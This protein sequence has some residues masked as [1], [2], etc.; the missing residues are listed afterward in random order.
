MFEKILLPLPSEYF[1]EHAV[2]RAI[3]LASKFKSKLFLEY[4][5][6]EQMMVKVDSVSSGAVPCQSLDQMV[7]EVKNVEVGSESSVVFD[8]V[9]SLAKKK[10]IDFQKII[11]SGNHSEEI[12]DC[13]NEQHIDLMV[14]EF[15]RDSLLKYRILYKSPAP[16]WLE[17]TGKKIE[18]VYGILTNISPNKLVPKFAFNLMNKFDVPLQFIYILDDSEPNNKDNEQNLR[19]KLQNELKKLGETFGIKYDFK[20]VNG[21]LPNFINQQ[22]KNEESSLIILGRFTKPVKLPF[23]NMDKKI[24][25]SK[26]LNANVLMLK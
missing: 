15:H 5:F 17:N 18:K 23:V 11:Q 9:E 13:I 20:V 4:I 10:N 24:E 7:E 25:V 21:K 6:N 1:P 8:E 14:T 12:L 16:V 3:Q 19:K 22:F 2:K 26:K